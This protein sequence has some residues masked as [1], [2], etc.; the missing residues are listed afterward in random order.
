MVVF[1]FCFA[2]MFTDVFRRTVTQ[3]LHRIKLLCCCG[4]RSSA[5]DSDIYRPIKRGKPYPIVQYKSPFLK[6]KN[7]RQNTWTVANANTCTSKTSDKQRSSKSTEYIMQNS[8]MKTNRATVNC[9]HEPEPNGLRSASPNLSTVSGGV[10]Y[11]SDSKLKSCEQ[12][13]L[14]PL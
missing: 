3:K 10:S 9:F 11:H 12:I 14:T 5:D 4:G 1:S 8:S 2:G 13:E 6:C 7:A